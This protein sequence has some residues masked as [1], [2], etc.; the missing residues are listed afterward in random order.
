LIWVSAGE[1]RRRRRVREG[2]I[3]VT[4]FVLAVTSPKAFEDEME[5]SGGAIG[6]GPGQHFDD[7]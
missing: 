3:Q 1:V 5:A 7:Y 4:K 6:S 2:G